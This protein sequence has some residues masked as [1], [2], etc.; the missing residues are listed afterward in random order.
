[1]FGYCYLSDVF[2]FEGCVASDWRMINE[3]LIFSSVETSDL[4]NL[5]GGTETK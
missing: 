5:H 1:V 2:N 3:K 4:Q